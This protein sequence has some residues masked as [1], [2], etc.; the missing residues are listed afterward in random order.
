MLSIF[1]QYGEQRKNESGGAADAYS[2]IKPERA[3]QDADV[4]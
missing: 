1:T 2:F 4:D 3:L